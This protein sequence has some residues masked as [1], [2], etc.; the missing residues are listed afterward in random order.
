MRVTDPARDE[1]L[2]RLDMLAVEQ[3]ERVRVRAHPGDVQVVTH[4]YP[5][6]GDGAA[7]HKTFV[8]GDTSATRRRD[9]RG[10][11]AG[12]PGIAGFGDGQ[13]PMAYPAHT[14]RANRTCRSWL[15]G[16]R[17]YYQ[18][19]AIGRLRDVGSGWSPYQLVGQRPAQYL[20][21]AI[22][23][24]GRCRSGSVTKAAAGTDQ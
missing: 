21:P 15:A 20:E 1:A 4:T 23:P 12:A 10:C 5:F 17:V 6:A 22:S 13:A 7:L 18:P 8:A 19:L 3:L 9:E 11:H 14:P 16:H 2:H 24:L